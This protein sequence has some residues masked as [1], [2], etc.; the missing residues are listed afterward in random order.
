MTS[1]PNRGDHRWRALPWGRPLGAVL[2]PPLLALAACSDVTNYA[3]DG[4]A[5]NLRDC[6]NWST[7]SIP[8]CYDGQGGRD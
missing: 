1:D 8:G 3:R 6:S 5:I 4:R 2:L 7:R